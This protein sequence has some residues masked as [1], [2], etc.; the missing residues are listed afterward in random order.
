MHY[1]CRSTANAML[2]AFEGITVLL[3]S[4]FAFVNCT[5]CCTLLHI[6][7]HIFAHNLVCFVNCTHFEL[8]IQHTAQSHH[9]YS[10]FL[11]HVAFRSCVSSLGI[12]I[13]TRYNDYSLLLMYVLKIYDLCFT[14]CILQVMH[15]LLKT[16]QFNSNGLYTHR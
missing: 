4:L 6:I 5:Y 1:L 12:S 15:C 7:A 9:D 8:Y 16:L 11:I 13:L 10:A 3:M 2:F 14:F